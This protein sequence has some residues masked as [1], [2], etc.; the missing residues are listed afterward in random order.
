MADNSEKATRKISPWSIIYP[1]IILIILAGAAGGFFYLK[2]MFSDLYSTAF[3]QVVADK[4][5]EVLAVK[6]QYEAEYSTYLNSQK[7]W[8]EV[9]KSTQEEINNAYGE[10]G[11]IYSERQALL[12]AEEARWNSLSE[13]EKRA[14]ELYNE[15]GKMME[16]IAYR[17]IDTYQ[18]IYE[19]FSG[20]LL[21]DIFNVDE[22]I[23]INYADSHKDFLDMIHAQRLQ[24]KLKEYALKHQAEQVGE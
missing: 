14:E 4:R 10:L 21:T 12:D 23:F 5:Q 22:E 13:E 24:Q 6:N 1:I 2:S 17:V 9:L 20:Y 8:E 3:E 18:R 19:N 16:K 11:R 15:Y 7:E